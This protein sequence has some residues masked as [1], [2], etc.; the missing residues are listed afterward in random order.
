MVSQANSKI[1]FNSSAKQQ[2]V[3]LVFYQIYINQKVI[4]LKSP[5]WNNCHIGTNKFPVS[6]FQY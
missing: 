4:S 3:L 5:D 6:N 1:S 2:T